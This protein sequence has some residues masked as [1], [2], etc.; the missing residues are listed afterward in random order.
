MAR[1]EERTPYVI[2]SFQECERMNVLMNEIRRSL[3]EL[4]LGLKVGIINTS[5]GIHIV[6]IRFDT[7]LVVVSNLQLARV[8]SLLINGTQFVKYERFRRNTNNIASRL[9]RRDDHRLSTF[10]F[11][12]LCSYINEI[13]YRNT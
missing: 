13:F 6:T 2:V 1:V 9:S 12:Y 8:C 11:S 3:K 10:L 4:H 7:R 5:N